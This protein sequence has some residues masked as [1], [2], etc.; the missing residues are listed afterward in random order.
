MII[1]GVIRKNE[2]YPS[3]RLGTGAGMSDYFVKVI[4]IQTL[5][6]RALT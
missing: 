3:W 5:M 4:S 1:F 2:K 6:R